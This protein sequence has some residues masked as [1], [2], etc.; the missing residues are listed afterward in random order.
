MEE[1]RIYA[2]KKRKSKVLLGKEFPFISDLKVGDKGQLEV[3]L[4][5]QSVS[6]IMD[7][8]G[9]EFKNLTVEIVEANLIEEKIYK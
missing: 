8:E 7:S 5:V 4:L 2:P 6:L 9:N 3:N 1:A